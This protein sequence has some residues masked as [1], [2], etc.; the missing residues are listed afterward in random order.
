MRTARI[1]HGVYIGF[2]RYTLIERT[3]IT[4]DDGKGGTV[5]QQKKI[6]IVE[7]EG[8]VALSLKA[9]LNKM[10]YLVTGMAYTG[11]EAIR[12]AAET[13]PDVILM[14]IHI[15]GD[16][17]G[18]Q[19]TEQSNKSADIPVIYL[20]AYAD[21]ETVAR[22]LKTRSHSYLVKPYN[23]R[24]LYS[25]I[26][27]AIYKRRLRDRIGTHRENIEMALT[28]V[29]DAG[30]II[31]L[32]DRI[33]YANPSSEVL[34]GWKV[35]EMIGN[36]INDVL[37]IAASSV[38]GMPDES[39]NRILSL[40]AMNY[41]APLAAIKMKSGKIRTVDLRV[42]LIKDDTDEHKNILFLMHEHPADLG[43]KK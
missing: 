8:V 32:K 23:P 11:E 28:K 19:A 2:R 37:D 4:D 26:E 31:D 42:G 20:T 9:V 17:D 30:I 21:D 40:G 15:K 33:V 10:G 14:D 3:S 12:L 18:I 34:T 1:M 6:L 27:L 25:N 35:D 22:A 36:N 5:M 16:M 7:D 13:K 38:N 29:P 39:L 43:M 41:L 24:E